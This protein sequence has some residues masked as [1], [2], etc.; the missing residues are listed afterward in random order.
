MGGYTHQEMREGAAP[1]WDRQISAEEVAVQA[2]LEA[3]TEEG[4]GLEAA[5]PAVGDP[6]GVSVVTLVGADLGRPEEA[7]GEGEEVGTGT[8][9][10]TGEK[11]KAD[12]SMLPR[13][14]E[15]WRVC[16]P[17]PGHSNCGSRGP[18]CCQAP[19][20]HCRSRSRSNLRWQGLCRCRSSSRCKWRAS[21][22]WRLRRL[23]R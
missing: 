8:E 16:T 1:C 6:V 17:C 11:E 12:R 23:R 22:W 14:T 20:T 21:H 19:E 9:A 10:G 4:A 5:E 2:G 18:S 13:G 15:C 3:V 7:A